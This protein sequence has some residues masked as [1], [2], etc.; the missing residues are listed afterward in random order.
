[1]VK[2]LPL[3]PDE[4]IPDLES[5]LSALHEMGPMEYEPGEQQRIAKEI[6]ELNKYSKE[7]MERRGR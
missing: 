5:R 1:L 4:A 7:I 2:I 3:T 6:E